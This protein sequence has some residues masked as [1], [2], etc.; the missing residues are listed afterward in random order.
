MTIQISDRL[1]PLKQIQLTRPGHVLFRRWAHLYRSRFPYQELAPLTAI[2]SSLIAGDTI[3]HGQ[4]DSA[5]H[6]WVAFTLLER[7]SSSTLLAYLATH[8]DFE[9]QGLAKRLVD[10]QLQKY[11]TKQTPYF[12]LEANPKLWPFYQKLGFQRLPIPYFIPEFYGSGTE[13][14]GLFVKTHSSV[15]AIS[16]SVVEKFVSELLLTG[17]GIKESDERYQKQMKLIQEYPQVEF[18]VENRH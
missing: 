14:M 5:S 7:Y 3:I 17:Y 12:W 10:E 8:S 13:F 15:N 9:G 16:K 6:Q 18:K 11:L 1:Q 2:E 4:L